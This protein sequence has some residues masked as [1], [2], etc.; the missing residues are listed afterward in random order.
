MIVTGSADIKTQNGDP[1]TSRG[2]ISRGPVYGILAR[3]YNRPLTPDF[4]SVLLRCGFLSALSGG[5]AYQ[6]LTVT[7]NSND[8]ADA[9]EYTRLFVGPSPMA[10]PYASMYRTDAQHPGELW[11]SGAS[12]V[13][14]YM[15][16]HGFRTVR[17]GMIPDHVSIMFEFMER[18]IAAEDNAKA[19]GE[20]DAQ[21]NAHRIQTEF[22][23]RYIQPWVGEFLGKIEAAR[24]Q[25]FYAAI[26]AFTETFMAQEEAYFTQRT[27]DRSDE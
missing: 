9:V 4:R 6:S 20:P 13:R 10:P 7:E 5:Q 17:A 25:P 21:P 8:I 22:F 2:H 14:R 11:G 24:P 16:H 1:M 3:L 15:S 27:L 19:G 18:L 12:E 23:A 26:A